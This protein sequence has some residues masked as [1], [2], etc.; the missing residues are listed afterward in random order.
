MMHKNPLYSLPPVLAEDYCAFSLRG[1]IR[2][3]KKIASD[4]IWMMNYLLLLSR[5]WL[6]ESLRINYETIFA[7]PL[8]SNYDSCWMID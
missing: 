7:I 8:D 5:C 3:N 6:V 4:Q 2:R 1:I